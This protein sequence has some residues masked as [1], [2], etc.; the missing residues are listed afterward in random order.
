MKEQ[1]TKTKKIFRKSIFDWVG[2]MKE[3]EFVFE[4]VR[5]IC[6]CEVSGD[7]ILT[8]EYD[9][10]RVNKYDSSEDR[11]LDFDDGEYCLYDSKDPEKGHY[12]EE[13]M[14]GLYLF[15]E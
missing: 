11:D 5:R 12:T 9:D 1:E 10:G 14:M 6:V 8:V 4:G 2:D 3:I 15:E 13:E 7:E